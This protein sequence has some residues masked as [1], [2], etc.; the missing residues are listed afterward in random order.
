MSMLMAQRAAE[1][2]LDPADAAALERMHRVDPIWRG[3]ALARDGIAFDGHTVLHAGPQVDLRNIAQPLLNSAAVAAVFEGWASDIAQAQIMI[4]GGEIK[5][6]PAQDVSAMVPLAAVL[7][8]NMFVQIVCDANNPGNRAFSPING[9]SPHEARFGLGH[10]RALAHLRWVNGNLGATLAI[11]ADRD[12]ALI[13][14]ADV[15]IAAGDDAHGRT[16]KASAAIV[17]ALSPRLGTDTPERRFLDAAPGFFLTLW[18]AAC[19]CVAQAGHGIDSSII[20]AL[21]GNGVDVGLQIGAA[22]G[23]WITTPATPPD[24]ILD[25][26]Y[27]EADRLGAIGDSALVDGL[28]F[29]A[30]LS[31]AN[32]D[33]AMLLPA[34]HAGFRLSSAHVGL[35][36]RCVA[37]SG[38]IPSVALGIIE[39]TGKHGRIGAGVYRAPAEPFLRADDI[40]TDHRKGRIES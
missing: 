22:P 12:L 10:N 32:P 27:T 40:I 29:G 36:I 18:M 21:G 33:A 7:S 35:P 25:A 23:Q 16:V 9:S 26:G 37:K 24:G 15:A 31:R 6:A 4:C 3:I 28:G 34:R 30:M 38:I 11:I 14:V 17:E 19:R 2:S 1:V 39:R 13:P 8:P 5:L 20:T